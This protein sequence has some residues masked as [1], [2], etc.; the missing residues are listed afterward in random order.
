MRCYLLHALLHPFNFVFL[1]FSGALS[2]TLCGVW[3]IPV[4]LTIDALA[5]IALSGRPR[6]RRAV[7]ELA[8]KIDRAELARHLSSI[9]AT[10]GPIHRKEYEELAEKLEQIRPEGGAAQRFVDEH[11]GPSRVLASYTR[12]A[13]IH[14]QWQEAQ[15]QVDRPGLSAEIAAVGAAITD[16]GSPAMAR[17]LIQRREVLRRR[18]AYWDRVQK[19]LEVVREEMRTVRELVALLHTLSAT[20]DDIEDARDEL[21]GCLGDLELWEPVVRRP[22]APVEGL[23][24]PVGDARREDDAPGPWVHSSLSYW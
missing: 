20:S 1:L 22:A 10:L 18:A 23:P 15:G 21:N 7:D 16:A 4:L 24:G 6:F 5:L 12:L 9:A 3:S 13:V 14:N 17:A 2:L 8:V 19:D 11:L